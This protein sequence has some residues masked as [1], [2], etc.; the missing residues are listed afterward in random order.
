MAYKNDL[1]LAFSGKEIA[2][3]RIEIIESTVFD[4]EAAESFSKE[5]R[6]KYQKLL[7]T[8]KERIAEI[9]SKIAEDIGVKQLQLD[10]Y[11]KE[12]TE[13]D[14]RHTLGELSFDEY[15]KKRS[16]ITKK[17]SKVDLEIG[18]LR[19]LLDASGSAEVG[20][21]IAIDID[22]E[23]DESGNIT[24]GSSINLKNLKIPGLFR[25]RS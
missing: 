8:S 4:S 19:H 1:Q 6:V 2:S 25:K 14:A 11:E 7:D 16:A 20:G 9:K 15:E 22:K 10:E 23:V 13:L 21:K 24:M 5:R 3:Q 12:M 18:E 17:S